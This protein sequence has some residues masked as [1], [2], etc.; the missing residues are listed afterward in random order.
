MKSEYRLTVRI[1]G[2]AGQKTANHVLRETTQ[3]K[4]GYVTSWLFPSNYSVRGSHTKCRKG[5]GGASHLSRLKFLV[6][7]LLFVSYKCNF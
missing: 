3:V 5:G 7:Y 6:L 2:D 1:K 4:E